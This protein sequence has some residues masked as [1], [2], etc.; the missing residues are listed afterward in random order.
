MSDDLK[1]QLR[2]T[3]SDEFAQVQIRMF[4]AR[5]PDLLTVDHIMVT[6]ADRRGPRAQPVARASA[7][8]FSTHDEW[9]GD[10]FRG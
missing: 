4:D 6:V 1:F 3:L 9:V 10:L 8:P 5:S 7:H 2:M